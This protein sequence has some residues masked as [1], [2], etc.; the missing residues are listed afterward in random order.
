MNSSQAAKTRKV[1]WRLMLLSLLVLSIT[2]YTTRVSVRPQVIDLASV[3]PFWTASITG[4]TG[5]VASVWVWTSTATLLTN[6]TVPGELRLARSEV[7]IQVRS[8]G[9][10]PLNLDVEG[11]TNHGSA[12]VRLLMGET[13]S[14]IFSSSIGRIPFLPVGRFGASTMPPLV[15]FGLRPVFDHPWSITMSR[16]DWVTNFPAG[17]RRD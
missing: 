15:P 5:D 14:A 16:Y 17:S 10:L 8:C 2:L 6:L 3:K 13:N 7:L 11:G 4:T 9:N 12:H 1:Y